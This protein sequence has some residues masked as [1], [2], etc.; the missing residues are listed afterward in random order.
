[1]ICY[2]VSFEIIG[3]RE[4][5]NNLCTNS[6]VGACVSMAN[7]SRLKSPHNINSVLPRDNPA[8]RLHSASVNAIELLDGGLYTV[9]NMNDLFVVG[10]LTFTYRDSIV[11][12]DILL[13]CTSVYLKSL[14]YKYPYT[15]FTQAYWS[16]RVVCAVA[17]NGVW[18]FSIWSPSQ[19]FVM[20]IPSNLQ[21]STESNAQ[22][23]SM[24]LLNNLIFKCNIFKSKLLY[25]SSN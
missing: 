2:P 24:L 23:S 9:P 15:A 14:R 4:N 16:Q 6:A 17:R 19:L 25:Y 1:M 18:G 12:F 5:E 3:A 21:V 20:H 11:W 13:P 10:W 22:R 8:I 7:K